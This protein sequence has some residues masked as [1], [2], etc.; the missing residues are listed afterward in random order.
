M[1]SKQHQYQVNLDLDRCS[2][3]AYEVLQVPSP[4]HLCEKLQGLYDGSILEDKI[5]SILKHRKSD[6]FIGFIFA[7][8]PPESVSTILKEASST[9]LF[10]KVVFIEVVVLD[11]QLLLLSKHIEHSSSSFISS[12]FKGVIILLKSLT[13]ILTLPPINS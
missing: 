6:H 9:S 12:T 4:S 1:T 2:H 13:P 10:L 5:I 11:L 3:E 8:S 7:T